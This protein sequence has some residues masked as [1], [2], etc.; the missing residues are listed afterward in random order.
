MWEFYI[1]DWVKLVS[2]KPFS[3]GNKKARIIAGAGTEKNLMAILAGCADPV[4]VTELCGT[5]PPNHYDW[6]DENFPGFLK[7]VGGNFD[8]CG[9]IVVAHGDKAY[10]YKHDWNKAGIPFEH[11]VAIFLLTY[12]RPW[13]DEVEKDGRRV[14]VG[15][16]VMDNYG[17]FLKFLPAPLTSEPT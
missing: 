16:W 10:G 17:R 3:N 5:F 9:G 6:L 4:P 2:G 11:G 12:L 15:Q 1:G 14:D 7:A 8:I 13:A